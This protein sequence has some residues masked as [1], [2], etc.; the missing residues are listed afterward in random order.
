MQNILS[1]ELC[2]V[3][4]DLFYAN[5]AMRHTAKSNLLNKIEIK[6]YLLPSLMRNP[7][8]GATV[9]DFIAILEPIDYSKFE[10]FSNVAD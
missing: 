10:R 4:L 2:P 3:P 6:W 1:R 8:L 7:D 5:G 9:M